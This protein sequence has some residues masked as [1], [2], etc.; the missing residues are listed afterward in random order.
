MTTECGWEL[1]PLVQKLGNSN[2][3]EVE[4]NS[5]GQPV[6]TVSDSSSSGT[7]SIT[8]SAIATSPDDDL[9]DADNSYT[10]TVQVL[11]ERE[12]LVVE[13]ACETDIFGNCVN[14]DG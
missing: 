12:Q 13:V 8:Y 3:I 4:L 10:F 11:T 6:I 5:D 14:D 9:D 1:T 7:F 2:A